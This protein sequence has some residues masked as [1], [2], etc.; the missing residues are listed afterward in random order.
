MILFDHMAVAGE[1]LAA[2]RSH[3]EDALGVAMQDG[4]EH[5]VF[6]TH[7]ALLGL[8]DG[9]YLEAIAI[10]PDAPVPDRPRWFDLDRFAGTPRLTNWICRSHGLD[11]T[12]AAVDL[13]LGAP[14][15]LQRGALRWRMAVPADGV[16]PFDNCAPA[17]I[18]WDCADHPADMLAQKGVRLRRLTIRHP[19]AEVLRVHLTSILSDDRI[20]FETGDAEMAAEFDTPAGL[21]VLA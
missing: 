15:S 18:Q 5:G 7:N 13:N 9:L 16:L 2:A 8:A 1:S 6:H 20:V 19:D 12:L 14:V 4:G 17:L 3:V 10:N 21:R 11:Q